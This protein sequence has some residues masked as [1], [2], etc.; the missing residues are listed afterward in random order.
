MKF[1]DIE[2]MSNKELKDDYEA[3]DQL[4]H[5]ENCCYGVKDAMYFYELENEI[6][7]RGLTITRKCEVTK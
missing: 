7:S 3:Y 5:G 6:I 4:L 2:K 1:K